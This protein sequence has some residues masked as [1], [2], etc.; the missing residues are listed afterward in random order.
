MISL[1]FVAFIWIIVFILIC[2]NWYQDDG[3]LFFLDLNRIGMMI[4]SLGTG[5][6][7]FALSDLYHPS[8]L[9]NAVSLIVFVIFWFFASNSRKDVSL[10]KECFGELKIPNNIIYWF[11]LALIAILAFFA[12]KANADAGQLRGLSNNAGMK[13]DFKGGY[14]YRLSVPIAICFYLVGR[15]AKQKLA[16]IFSLL[17]FVAFLYFTACDLSRGPI[18]WILTGCLLFELL[19][20]VKRTGK[21][22]VSGK[23]FLLLVGV[24][25]AVVFAFD[26]FGSIRTATLFSSVSSQYKM[27][28]DVPDGFTW[29]YIYISSPL[30]NARYALD[31]IVVKTPTFGAHLFY[32]FIKLFSNFLGFDTTFS[33]WLGSSTVVYSYMATDPGLTV[34]SFL[35]DAFQDFSILGIVIY[36][37]F[38]GLVSLLVKAMLNWQRFS[39]LTKLITYS[40]A[41]QGPLWSIFDDTVF[42][43]PLWVCAFAVI[44]IDLLTTFFTTRTRGNEKNETESR[45]YIEERG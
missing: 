31:N 36:P 32:P 42:S 24:F 6:Y 26:Y 7:D 15:M 2:Y 13:V 44:A 25:V 41:I 4:W 27:N 39:S 22:K 23:T 33:S 34:G 28:V 5:L 3:V 9:I 17:L 8:L 40:L 29:L 45:L 21:T 10:L 37:L 38:Y 12:F 11:F 35:M 43:G 19:L 16:K 30:E 20:Y 1:F 18:V 14:F